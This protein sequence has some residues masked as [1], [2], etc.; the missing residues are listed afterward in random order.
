MDNGGGREYTGNLNFTV[1]LKLLLKKK[2]SL[3][4]KS[5]YSQGGYRF[6]D[7]LFS[8]LFFFFFFVSLSFVGP[9]PGHMEVLRLGG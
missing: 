6:P 4:S 3:N 7:F 2:K 9:H 1:N 5:I 8:F